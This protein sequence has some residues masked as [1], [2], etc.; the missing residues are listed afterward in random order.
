MR[1][2]QRPVVTV[3]DA[4]QKG[5]S[6]K[7]V[8]DEDG[9]ASCNQIKRDIDAGVF[10][11]ALFHAIRP[12]YKCLALWK[13]NI[14]RSPWVES[15]TNDAFGPFEPDDPGEMTVERWVKQNYDA[16]KAGQAIKE[17][18]VKDSFRAAFPMMPGQVPVAMRDAG[19]IL[20]KSNGTFRYVMFEFVAGEGRK[21]VGPKRPAQP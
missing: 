20:D 6:F 14:P 4:T 3:V 16:S 21:P 13:D 12:L 5:N 9:Q 2:V 17:T 8:P 11:N 1:D 10:N 15:S 19:F 7:S 18:V